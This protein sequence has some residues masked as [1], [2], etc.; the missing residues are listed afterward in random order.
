M[1][2]GEL[3]PCSQVLILSGD[4]FLSVG[5]ILRVKSLLR[6]E[7]Q[8]KKK[9]RCQGA[10]KENDLVCF[11]VSLIS[12]SLF[13]RWLLG[14]IIKSAVLLPS[15]GEANTAEHKIPFYWAIKSKNRVYNLLCFDKKL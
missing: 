8:F 12:L 7:I 11:G 2:V 13:K 6:F 3:H 4:A 10:D 9:K 14:K 5:F 1:A 15:P